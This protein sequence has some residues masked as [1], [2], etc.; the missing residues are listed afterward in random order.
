MNTKFRQIGEQVLIVF[1]IFILFLLLFAS[2][3]VLPYWLQPAGRL[4]TLMLH[5]PIVLLILAIGMD[6]FRFRANNYANT[7]YTN[8]TRYLLLSGTLLAG[9]TVVMG[10][11]LSKEEGYTGDTL[12][13]HK[14]TG[15]SLFFIASLIYWLRNKKWY[16]TPV[17]AVSTFIVM[18]S[19]VMTGHYGATLTHGDNFILQPITATFTKP[20]VPLEAAVIFAD[21]IQ[22]ILEKKCVSCHNAHKLKGELA[23]TDSLAIMKGGKSGKLFVP[24]NTAISLLLERVHLSLDEEKHMPPQGKPQLTGVE[25]ALLSLW[26]NA[27]AGFNK[28]VITLPVNDSLRL[29]ATTV[30]QPVI[31]STFLFDFAAADKKVITKLN[32]NYLTIAQFS[33][34][35]PALE[36]SIYNR[37]A[38]SV[39]QLDELS[40]IQKQVISLNLN[41][42]PVKDEDLKTVSHFE[43][44]RR[45]DLNFSEVTDNG[46]NALL[47]LKHLHTLSLSGTKVSYNGLKEKLAALKKLKT[48][49]IWNT[50]ISVQQV[51]EL[52]HAYKDITFIEGFSADGKD[53]LKLNL[54][55]IKNSTMVFG[56]A[57]SVQLK[58]P[59]RGVE[60][61]YTMDGSAPDSMHAQIFENNTIIS[62][63]TKIKAKAYKAGWYSSDIAEFDFL[64]NTFIPDSVRLLYPLNSVHLAEGAH[65][66]FDTRL[67]TIG[68]NN[69]AWANFW[70]GV[71]NNDMGL[72]SLF[73]KPITLSSVGLHYMVEEET[74]IYPPAVIEIWGGDS[75][76]NIK[77]LL[78]LSPSLPIKGEKPSLK[79][80][81]GRFKS[82]KLSYLKII[83]KPYIKGKDRHLLLID[84]MF[85]N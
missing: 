65:T 50:G 55:L 40:E 11:F 6:L 23:L 41:K 14:W 45:L 68:A 53:T 15:A 22:P 78:K 21:V 35:S 62:K 1:N 71:R 7:F 10:L 30:L 60:I 82:R 64:K 24:G 18:G 54:P 52:Q 49:S 61:R 43:N 46:L 5:F 28:K 63:T 44:L 4:H 3:L 26:I 67:G 29:I 58:H 16:R 12:Q 2:K 83:A 8:S 66:F 13:W 33:K 57:I 47:S 42:L 70:A 19:L 72:E 20:L 81:E 73:Y 84:E 77:L 25:I 48:I 59:I 32:T 80:V 9:I 85:L 51:T 36:V 27:E 37:D 79:F 74:G 17:A 69:P 38:Y 39:K 75:P 56:E 34:E 76:Q 31:D